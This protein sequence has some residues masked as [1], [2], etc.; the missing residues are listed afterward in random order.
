MKKYLYLALLAPS[1]LMAQEVPSLF[2]LATRSVAASEKFNLDALNQECR[3]AV[4]FERTKQKLWPAFEKG[5][6]GSEKLDRWFWDDPEKRKLT[7][8]EVR[9]NVYF[10]LAIA[11]RHKKYDQHTGFDLWDEQGQRMFQ[12]TIVPERQMTIIEVGSSKFDEFLDT[13]PEVEKHHGN[14]VKYLNTLNT[15]R[16]SIFSGFIF[17]EAVNPSSPRSYPFSDAVDFDKQMERINDID[18]LSQ[19]AS[20]KN[21]TEKIVDK[22]VL[23]FYSDDTFKN[24]QGN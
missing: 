11:L 15:G 21:N 12:T 3:K 14:S 23:A 19:Q 17:I 18:L 1:L 4:K 7:P 9:K 24:V 6:K 20:K 8:T 22:N 2:S 13:L 16:S 10:D 5:W